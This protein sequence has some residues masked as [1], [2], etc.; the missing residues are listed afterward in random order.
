MRFL[1]FFK[2]HCNTL[3]N[4]TVSCPTSLVSIPLLFLG[5]DTSRPPFRKVR[6]PFRSRSRD[7]VLVPNIDQVFLY[8]EHIDL[9]LFSSVNESRSVYGT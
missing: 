6:L 4:P 3:S 2:L 7:S 5:K 8:D 1:L 9:I